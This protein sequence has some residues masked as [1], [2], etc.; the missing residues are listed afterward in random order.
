[1]EACIL[2]PVVSCH[3]IFNERPH[4]GTKMLG[5]ASRGKFLFFDPENRL[6]EPQYVHGKIKEFEEDEWNY[7]SQR[8]KETF[9]LANIPVIK[10]DNKEFINV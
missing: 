8:V 10:E 6:L 9:E 7:Y 1:L 4:L 5:G 2:I 3:L